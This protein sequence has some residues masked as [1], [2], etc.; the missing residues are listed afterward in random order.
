MIK[1]IVISGGS[2]NGIKTYGAL[3]ELAKQNFYD[4]KN[5]ETIYGTSVGSVIGTILTLKIDN[6]I[7]FDYV[8]KRPWYKISNIK[9]ISLKKKGLLDKTFIEEIM[10]PILNSKGLDVN[11][12]MKELYSYTNI[13]QHIF[14]TRLTDMK[15]VDISYKSHPNLPIIDAIYMSS[16]IPY[17][18]EPHYYDGDFYIDGG[19]LCNF[20]LDHCSKDPDT[21]LGVQ[22]NNS[23]NHSLNNGI[24][25]TILEYFV[26][27]NYNLF[28]CLGAISER[29]IKH[30]LVIEV[31]KIDKSEF[32]KILYESETRLR[33]LNSGQEI[34][35]NFIQSINDKREV[36]I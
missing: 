16:A 29:K 24:D 9:N 25:A 11:I 3:Y 36:D 28:K 12:T 35:N 32:D 30:K 27:L 20:P 8:H 21:I 31:N 14:T 13:E 4:I 34:A 23:S 15:L 2:Y 10:N 19:V 7:I 6:K 33:F 17:F 26:F 18:L 22:T 1:H 5:I